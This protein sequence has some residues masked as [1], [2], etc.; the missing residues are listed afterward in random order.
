MPPAVV[1]AV[2]AFKG[3]KVPHNPNRA[4]A[5]ID[6]TRPYLARNPLF[7]YSLRVPLDESIATEFPSPF[8]AEPDFT[9][10]PPLLYSVDQPVEKCLAAHMHKYPH[11]SQPAI[12]ECPVVIDTVDPATGLQT[13]QRRVVC[14]NIAPWLARKALGGGDT[15]ELIEDSTFDPVTRTFDLRS[16]NTAFA[17]VVTAREATRMRPHKENPEWTA[18]VQYGGIR[19]STYLGPLKRTLEHF[20]CDRMQTGGLQA[21]DLLDDILH[22]QSSFD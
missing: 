11:P 19:C 4:G 17:K 10:S 3:K 1:A 12:L 6:A 8:A 7:T 14:K 20:I 13:R 5:P 21:M 9:A 15:I 2:D 22:T 18:F 16:H